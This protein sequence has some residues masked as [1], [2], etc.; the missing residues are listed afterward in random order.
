MIRGAVPQENWADLFR[1]F[2]GSAARMQLLQLHLGVQF[3]LE[4]GLE[5]AINPD[6][7][8]FK[9]MREAAKQLGLNLEIQDYSFALFR[10]CH[11]GPPNSQKEA[12]YA[13][14]DFG[15]VHGLAQERR[16]ANGHLEALRCA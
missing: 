5:K 4:T 10:G 15:R 13:T 2:V 8:A 3:E 6:D 16:S 11:P 1:C 9:A 14:F 12:S 7:P